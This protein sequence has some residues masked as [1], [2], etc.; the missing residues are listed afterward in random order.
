MSPCIASHCPPPA[1]R[2]GGALATAARVARRRA[3]T[4]VGNP[5]SAFKPGELCAAS[6]SRRRLKNAT[7][8]VASDDRGSTFGAVLRDGLLRLT[9]SSHHGV[10]EG[11]VSERGR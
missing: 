9:V 3:R 7:S 4:F 10:V 1:N 8:C 5:S 6:S 2:F 11:D